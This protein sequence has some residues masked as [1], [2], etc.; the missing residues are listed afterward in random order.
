MTQR[1][2]GRGEREERG[3]GE[4]GER[5]RGREGG[6]EKRERE[7]E[8]EGGKGILKHALSPAYFLL[9]QLQAIQLHVAKA[10][11]DGS[12]EVSLLFVRKVV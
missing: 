1:V 4:G 12:D 5:V 3:A 7:R 6:E 10:T 9:V 2:G 8:R 11:N